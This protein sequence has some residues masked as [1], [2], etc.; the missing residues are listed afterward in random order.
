MGFTA[1]E[2]LQATAGAVLLVII[3]WASLVIVIVA[4]S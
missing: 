4:A 2:W 3:A 1:R